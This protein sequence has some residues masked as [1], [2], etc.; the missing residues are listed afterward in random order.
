MEHSQGSRP[1]ILLVEDDVPA[2]AALARWL[3]YE[4]DVVTARDGLEGL[5]IATTREPAPDLIITD[6]W[7]PRLDGVEM[8]SRI[9]AI[10][11]L[12]RIPVIFL[13]GQNSPKSVIAG[14]SAGARAYLPKPVDLA[15]LDRK[16]K[17]ALQHR[18]S[19]P[20]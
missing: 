9:K 14:I 12:H 18:G 19:L 4:Y 2:L 7:M 6:M 17:S 15:V 10:Q 8:V 3:E 20:P 16:V 5:E 11:A 13:T 1:R